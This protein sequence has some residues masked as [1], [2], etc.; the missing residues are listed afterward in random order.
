MVI[1][2]NSH[3]VQWKPCSPGP[4]VCDPGWLLLAHICNATNGNLSHQ[5][6]IS[7]FFLLYHEGSVVDNSSTSVFTNSLMLR[8]TKFLEHKVGWWPW[9]ILVSGSCFTILCSDLL[10]LT[11]GIF[12]HDHLMMFWAPR[13]HFFAMA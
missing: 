4:H 8:F 13:N 7:I 12:D 5:C 3:S 10:K 9:H 11:F 6:I 1:L 2:Q